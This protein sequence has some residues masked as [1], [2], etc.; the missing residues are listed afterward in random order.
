MK[1]PYS[2]APPKFIAFLLPLFMLFSVS[3]NAQW[4]FRD[5][6]KHDN[7]TYP[8]SS[9]RAQVS[10]EIGITTIS[11][12]YHQPGVRNRVI[13]GGL[14]PFGQVWRAGA[15]ESTVIT[16]MDAVKVNGSAVP[17]GKYGLHMIPEA[18]K[19]IIILSKNHTQWGSFYYQATEDLLRIEVNTEKA[20]FREYL[21]YGFDLKNENTTDLFMSWAGLKVRLEIEVDETAT[22]L[23]VIRDELRTLPRFTWRG[24]REA[25]LFCWLHDVNLEEA[26]QWINLSI[27]IEERFENVFIKSRILASLGQK[28]ASEEALSLAK[29]L[30]DVNDMIFVAAETVGH[31]NSPEKAL[32]VL[33]IAEDNYPTNYQVDFRRAICYG[34]LGDLEKTKA[35]FNSALTKATSESEKTRVLQRMKEYGLK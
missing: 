7:I 10:Q 1:T 11:V 34:W 5:V 4:E 19:F 35:F 16:F 21:H 13:W 28:E 6:I 12:M 17:A 33:S 23:A 32:E 29:Q 22:T 30:G 14:I 9:K 25:A 27:R 20:P 26:L 2:F 3:L 24:S 31:H 15:E 8:K 18:D